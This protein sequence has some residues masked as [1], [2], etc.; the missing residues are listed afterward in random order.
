VEGSTR[1]HDG[2]ADY[3]CNRDFG[4]LQQLYGRATHSGILEGG[5]AVFADALDWLVAFSLRN[6]ATKKAFTIL[7][8]ERFVFIANTSQD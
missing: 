3:G 7:T 5:R 2:V 6:T 1:R 4:F 8:C